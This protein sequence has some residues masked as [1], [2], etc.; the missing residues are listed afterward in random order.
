LEKLEKLEDKTEIDIKGA[1]ERNEIYKNHKIPAFL[2]IAWAILISSAI[3]Y[4]LKYAIP[5]LRT[6]LAK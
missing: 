2:I 6:W 5:D 4:S 3:Y 1:T